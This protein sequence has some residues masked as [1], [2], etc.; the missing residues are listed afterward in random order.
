MIVAI[1]GT[2]DA[3]HMLLLL[4]QTHR[5]SKWNKPLII[6]QNLTIQKIYANQFTPMS[7]IRLL[8]VWQIITIN[9]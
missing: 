4:I 1:Q 2:N 8:F 5:K 7:A 6:C 9:M 3:H